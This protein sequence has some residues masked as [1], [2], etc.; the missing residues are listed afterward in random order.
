MYA[1]KG[2]VHSLCIQL[3][4]FLR[5]VLRLFAICRS[6]FTSRYAKRSHKWKKK[7]KR[8]IRKPRT[9]RNSEFAD[10]SRA[11]QYFL[12]HCIIRISILCLII[13]CLLVCNSELFLNFL[14]NVGS[15]F[16]SSSISIQCNVHMYIHVIFSRICTKKHFHFLHAFYE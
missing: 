9:E 5:L 13:K 6:E 8:R 1:F 2:C 11:T 14:W 10:G 7:K 15:H 4:L 3:V 12:R 16:H